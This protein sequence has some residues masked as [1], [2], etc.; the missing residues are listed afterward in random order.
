MRRR[1]IIGYLAAAAVAGPN[2]ARAQQAARPRVG[3]LIPVN[4]EAFLDEFRT[5]LREFGYVEG[6]NIQ[7][8]IR[9][10]DGKIDLLPR[11]AEELVRLRVDIIVANLTP[12][13]FA[14]REATKEIPIVMAPSGDPLGTG[15]VANLARPGGNITGLA[16]TGPEL[17]EKLVEYIR[18][19]LP[20]AR[21]LA[22]LANA[23]DPFARPFGALI[24][25][26]GKSLGF[27][28]QTLP[29]RGAEEFEAAFAAMVREKAEAV[30][31][32]PS[33]PR[34]AAI[35]LAM[36]QQLPTFSVISSFPDD[37]GLLAFSAVQTFGRAAYFVDRII[38]GS[39]PGDLAV[40]QPSRY[41][42]VV[43]LKTAKTLGLAISPLVL[44]QADKI[45]E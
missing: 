4:P 18:A 45:I 19:I 8:E 44:T 31:V 22:F 40:E 21:R 14:A 11:L 34:R 17:G 7:L 28:I 24:E 30:I 16:S 13:V 1:E 15:L 5:A 10:A 6:Q 43:N 3:V 37:G 36:K 2:G 12:S 25:R 42:L 38:K 35:E 41:E 26:G 20:N 32:Q 33:L 27:G 9:S 23:S 39:R 29:V